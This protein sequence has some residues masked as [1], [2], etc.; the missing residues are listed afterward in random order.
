[1]FA[2]PALPVQSKPLSFRLRDARKHAHLHNGLARVSG[3]FRLDRANHITQHRQQSSQTPR[4][5]IKRNNNGNIL[6]IPPTKKP[7]HAPSAPRRL[8]LEARQRAIAVFDLDFALVEQHVGRDVAAGDF[9]AVGARAQMAA[10]SG[11]EVAIGCGDG[12]A[13]ATAEAGAGHAGGEG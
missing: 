6:P 7:K 11:E 8:V 2:F 4:G 3:G 10:G 5:M 13:Y 9:A 12:C 1:M